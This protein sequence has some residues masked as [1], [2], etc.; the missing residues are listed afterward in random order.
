MSLLVISKIL[1]LVIEIIFQFSLE[2][3]VNL[4]ISWS[5]TGIPEGF[6]HDISAAVICSVVSPALIH[7]STFILKITIQLRTYF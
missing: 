3:M 1:K 7:S 4:T 5:T 2:K 6:C